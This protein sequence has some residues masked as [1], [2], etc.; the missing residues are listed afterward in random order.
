M[1]PILEFYVS[2]F[3][4]WLGITIALSIVCDGAGR[5]FRHLRS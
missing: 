3:W 1:L 5:L 2:D 4:T